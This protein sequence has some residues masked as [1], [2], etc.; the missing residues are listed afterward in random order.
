[1][2]MEVD[3]RTIREAGLGKGFRVLEPHDGY[4]GDNSLW[5]GKCAVCME[6]VTHSRLTGLWEHTV[7]TLVEY[8][9]KDSTFPNH[10]V[11]HKVDYCPV[12]EGKVIEPEIIRP[13]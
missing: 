10:T 6:L 5:F 9:S 2:L 8:W 13:A 4:R 7:Y 12:V 3:F 11:S 1:M